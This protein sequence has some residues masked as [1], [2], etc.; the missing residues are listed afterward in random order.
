MVW[1]PTGHQT[2]APLLSGAGFSFGTNPSEEPELSAPA[3]TLGS[4]VRFHARGGTN[5]EWARPTLDLRDVPDAAG[6]P[7][8]PEMKGE[9]QGRRHTVERAWV[10][11]RSGTLQSS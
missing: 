11:L 1:I 10:S 3:S 7:P 8:E 9:H 5:M 2:S 4:V 6:G